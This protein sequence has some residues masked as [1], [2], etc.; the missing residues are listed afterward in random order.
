MLFDRWR[1]RVHHEGTLA[2]PGEYDWTCASF[3]SLRCT[4]KRQMDQFN[5]FCTAYNRKCLYFTMRA[6]SSTNL[7]FPAHL[8]FP[9]FNSNTFHLSVTFKQLRTLPA[10]THFTFS[11]LQASATL[12][13]PMILVS[14]TRPWQTDQPTDRA[15]DRPT[16]QATRCEAA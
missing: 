10:L 15:T 2:P 13:K 4:P 16:D 9:T 7:Q 8:T 3:G 1:Q 6:P 5:R 14:W 11:N 12:D